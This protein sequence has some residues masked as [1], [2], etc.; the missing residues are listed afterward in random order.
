[1]KVLHSV[2]VLV[3]CLLTIP[4][5]RAQTKKLTAAEAK[6]HVGESSDPLRQSGQHALRQEFKRRTNV[7]KSR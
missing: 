3:F 1:M 2:V 4:S 7:S 6:D 5:L